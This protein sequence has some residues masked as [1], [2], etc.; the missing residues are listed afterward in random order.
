MRKMLTVLLVLILGVSV[1]GCSN[2]SKQEETSK[3]TEKETQVAETKKTEEKDEV[4]E[5]R[6]LTRNTGT[7]KRVVIFNEVLKAFDESHDDVVIIDES[8]GDESS[9]NNKLKTDIASGTV[10]NIFRIQGVAN[11]GNYI[12]NGM[13]MNWDPVLEADPEWAA[14]FPEGAL[15]Y[16]QVPGYEGTYGI[17]MESGLIAMFYNEKLFNEAGIQFP[18][19]YD[20]L[21]AAVE[22]F[23]SR[24]IIPIALGAKSTYMAGHLHNQ[25]FYKWLGT[26]RAKDLG[27]RELKW[28]DPEVIETLEL[29][30]EVFEAGAL[31]EGV[32]GVSDDVVTAQFK[33]G[34]AAMMITGP[35][36]IGRFVDSEETP[37]AEHIR[38]A[39]FPYFKEK[40]E[41]KDE[42]MQIISPYMVNGQLKGKELEY[43]IELV[44]TLTSPEVAKRYVEE[45]QHI[46]PRTDVEIDDSK[47]SQLFK[48]V[49]ELGST[50]T[51][52]AVDVF[53]YDPLASMQDRTRNSIIGMFV[54]NTPE[55][56]AEEI[57]KEIDKNK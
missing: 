51:G 43:T 5:I 34:E 23:K 13:I 39:K 52:I 36:N 26:D 4:V 37:M 2:N 28:T 53:D 11:L 44:K 6:L 48:D 27:S 55:Q 32:A 16:Y 14:G 42:D 38:I 12:D 50:S 17:P 49:V 19:T 18:E 57:Q 8:Q 33:K 20:E 25:I 54:G 29:V 30:Q 3:G 24:D 45:A 31:P 56:A 9:F 35:W 46:I 47:V 21:L 40:P 22:V 10:P 15:K 1:F 41:F 7:S